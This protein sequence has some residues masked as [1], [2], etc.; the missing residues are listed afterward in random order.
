MKPNLQKALFEQYLSGDLDI[1]K[2]NRE[3][4]EENECSLRTITSLRAKIR[5]H[6]EKQKEALEYGIEYSRISERKRELTKEYDEKLREIMDY[7]YLEYSSKDVEKKREL[8][9]KSAKGFIDLPI[10]M[11]EREGENIE[12]YG[13]GLVKTNLKKAMRTLNRYSKDR[14]RDYDIQ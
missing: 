3:L 9:A 12:K 4:S 8:L 11:L 14:K 2:T 7:Y 6:I 10:M 1:S 5:E 13:M